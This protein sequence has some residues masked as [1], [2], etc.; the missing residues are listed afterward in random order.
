MSDDNIRQVKSNNG[1]GLGRH[2]LEFTRVVPKFLAKLK[3]TNSD[4][5]EVELGDKFKQYIGT[6]D[7]DNNDNVEDA[8][9]KEAIAMAMKD[10]ETLEKDVKEKKDIQEQQKQQEYEAQRL[11]RIEQDQLEEEKAKEQG[12]Q[13]KLVFQKPLKKP[14]ATASSSTLKDTMSTIKKT[15]TKPKE[16]LQKKSAPKRLSFN[17]D[18]E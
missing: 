15:N 7:D 8:Q 11:K 1:K 12:V 2:Q 5:R 17:D 6:D 16:Q 3:S 4:A 18:E 13:R 9:E 10:M 14:S